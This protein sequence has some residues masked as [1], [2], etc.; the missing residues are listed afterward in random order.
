M[1]K[2]FKRTDQPML[3]LVPG[4]GGDALD[5]LVVALDEAG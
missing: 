2:H 3:P 4:N 5:L 1:H